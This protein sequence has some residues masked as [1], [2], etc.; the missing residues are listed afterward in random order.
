[1]FEFIRK[2]TRLALGLLLLL[3]IPSFVFFGVEGYT[4]FADGGNATVAKVGRNEITRIEWDQTHQRQVERV[5]R[6]NP[7]IDAATLDTPQAR[8]ETLDGLIRDRV[9]LAA[10]SEL[11]LYP[12][13]GRM[14]RLFDSDP[15]F[16]GLRGPDGRISRELLAVQGMTPEMF[17]Q[18]LRQ[19]LAMRQVVAGVQSS[20]FT[21]PGVAAAAL[22]PM[23]QRR[24]VQL[25]VFDASVY[26]SRVQ[27]TDAD[28]QT[29]YEANE[30]S[31]R[32]PEQAEIE[33]V[34]LDIDQLSKDVAVS[35]GDLR[36]YYQENASRYTQA[37]ERRASHI[38]I[39]AAEDAPAEERK[40][41]RERAEGLVAELRRNPAAFAD[42]A[43]RHSQDPGSAAQGGDLD[44]FG[45]GSMVKPFED[46]VYAMKTGEISNPI[47]TEFGY[48]IIRLAAVRGGERQ[49]F[50][51][52][53]GEI[54]AE[55]RRT[56]A[57]RRWAEAA[58]QFTN[59]VYEQSDTFQPLVDKLGLKPQ[60]AVV[61]RQAQVGAEGALAQQRLL[62]AVF[63][64]DSVREKRNTDAIEFGVNQMASA[65]LL[66]HEPERTL[67]LAD[68]RDQVRESVIAARA[69][70]LAR[71]DA[72][73]RLEEL[74]AKPEEV[75]PTTVVLSRMNTQ[76]A[77]SEVVEAVLAADAT[78]LPALTEAPLGQGG[79][80]IMR[81]TQVLPREQLPGGDA[82]L[83]QQ[84]AQ[85]FAVAESQA[86]L[87]AL[88]KRFKAEVTPAAGAAR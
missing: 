2:H 76:G 50:E 46:A 32:R 71:E 16:S 33:Y 54:E 83:Q 4:R 67:P 26:R 6:Q 63:A 27:P 75:L 77:P 82:P 81:V 7:D 87:E 79:H 44:F 1:M 74:R 78:R 47:E 14:Q 15:Q 69:A 30:S 19:D 68:V 80:V 65:R 51:Q 36:T 25:Q 70:E 38:L 56:L 39:T 31:F 86:Y 57:Q 53:R 21:T 3:I 52:V 66:S 49:P 45:R 24:E 8:R 43:R 29:Y 62:D 35:E 18:R 59:T 11:Q 60:R 61:H 42:L 13:V 23:L 40:A 41:A 17:D 64:S 84:L 10:A 85:A 12:T 48:H 58:E 5:R 73:K 28:L 88:K 37:E 20:A 55:L 72:R 34:V 9:L 22:E